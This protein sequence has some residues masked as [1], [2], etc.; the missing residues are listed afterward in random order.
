MAKRRTEAEKKRRSRRED[1]KRGQD[2]PGGRS[3][4][5][6]KRAY[7]AKAGKWGFECPT[8]PW[9]IGAG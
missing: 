9:R 5:A 4:Y 2:N 3:K 8:K 6:V 1:K 7:L